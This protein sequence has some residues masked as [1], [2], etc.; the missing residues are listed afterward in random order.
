LET[1]QERNQVF[2]IWLVFR[3]DLGINIVIHT[4]SLF[5]DVKT[6]NL[7]FLRTGVNVK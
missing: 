1:L 6:Y 3:E 7:Y 5:A 4:C 2:D